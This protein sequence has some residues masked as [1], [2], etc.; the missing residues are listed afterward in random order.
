MVKLLIKL[1]SENLSEVLDSIHPILLYLIIFVVKI[2]E[3]AMATIRIVFITKGEKL[4]G[5]LIG[6]VEVIIWVLLAATVLTDVTSDPMKVIVYALAFAIGNYV[7]SMVENKLAIGTVNI[8]AIVKKAHGKQMSIA[9][10]ELGFA[11]TAV[12]AYGRDDRK[13]ILYMHVPRKKIASTIKLIKSHQQDVVI[14]VNDI[15][16]IYGGHGILRK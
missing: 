1:R 14:T 4:K 12:D 2:V 6:F 15:R 16:P 7:G 8:E 5:A 11:V 3:V 13:E 10:R 9:L